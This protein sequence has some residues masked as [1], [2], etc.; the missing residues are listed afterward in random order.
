MN[1]IL[2]RCFICAICMCVYIYIYVR[3]VHIIIMYPATRSQQIYTCKCIYK[4]SRY[5]SKTLSLKNYRT[6]ELVLGIFIYV[7]NTRIS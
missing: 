1:N 7:Y 6:V 2:H 3:T 5:K 4:L